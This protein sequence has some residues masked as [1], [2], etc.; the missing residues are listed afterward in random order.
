[1]CGLR[2]GVWDPSRLS[3]FGLRPACCSVSG[4]PHGRLGRLHGLCDSGWERSVL[5]VVHIL[6]HGLP[7]CPE[8][9][10]NDWPSD[11]RWVSFKDYPAIIGTESFCLECVHVFENQSE[12]T[13]LRT[14]CPKCGH[15]LRLDVEKGFIS[16][17][18]RCGGCDRSVGLHINS[19]PCIVY[20]PPEYDGDP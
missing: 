13:E 9:P 1:M 12:T 16:A 5:R 18:V 19:G 11:H 20:P 7:L 3:R 17:T 10:P 8:G 14:A 4:I 15:E 6:R 2:E